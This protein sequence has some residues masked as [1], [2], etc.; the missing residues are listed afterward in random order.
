MKHPVST[1]KNK[2]ARDPLATRSV[3]GRATP[4]LAGAPLRQEDHIFGERH[5]SALH[6]AH[7]VPNSH[8]IAIW[9]HVHGHIGSI[10]CAWASKPVCSA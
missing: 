1:V 2:A 6:E 8:P 5:L 10:A 7:P 3:F 4:I 9:A